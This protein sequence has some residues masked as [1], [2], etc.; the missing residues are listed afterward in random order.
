MT[1]F[2]QDGHDYTDKAMGNGRVGNDRHYIY[3][4]A[5]TFMGEV[6]K[7]CCGE[8]WIYDGDTCGTIH[9]NEPDAYVTARQCLVAG[10]I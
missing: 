4:A 3:D 1:T 10:I 5:G 8:Y 9:E 6:F 2:T 7:S